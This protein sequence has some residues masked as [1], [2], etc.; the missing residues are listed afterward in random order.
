[1]EREIAETLAVRKVGHFKS[2]EPA[3]IW[4]NSRGGQKG[5]RERKKGGSVVDQHHALKFYRIN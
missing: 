3:I 2:W 1:M 4:A 5:E